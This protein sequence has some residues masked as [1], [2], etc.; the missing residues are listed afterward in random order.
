MAW[1]DS[2]I[3]VDGY[4]RRC[5][6]DYENS[7]LWDMLRARLKDRPGTLQVQKIKSHVTAVCLRVAFF[8]SQGL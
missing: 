1:V 6:E 3:T 5:D 8:P 4:A 7:D 2:K